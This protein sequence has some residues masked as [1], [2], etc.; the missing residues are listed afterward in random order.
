MFF[1]VL[2]AYG[3]FEVSKTGSRASPDQVQICPSDV[4][5]MSVRCPMIIFLSATF[6]TWSM[7]LP[8]VSSLKNRSKTGIPPV[9]A[10]G[11][12]QVSAQLPN[13]SPPLHISK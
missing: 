6:W 9:M 13:D 5:P 11:R 10:K 3:V 8:G 7:P 4:R 12:E 1:Q 2:R